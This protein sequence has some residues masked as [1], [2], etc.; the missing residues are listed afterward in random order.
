MDPHESR[1]HRRSHNNDELKDEGGQD[2][3]PHRD[4]SGGLEERQESELS[5]QSPIEGDQDDILQSKGM[6]GEEQ[7][8]QD[9]SGGLKV[10][11]KSQQLDSPDKSGEEHCLKVKGNDG[12]KRRG[13]E[14]RGRGSRKRARRVD[15]HPTESTKKKTPRLDWTQLKGLMKEERKRRTRRSS[16]QMVYLR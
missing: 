4:D 9:G 6:V 7:P 14:R 1:L 13:K 8:D 11:Q 3:Q 5:L 16:H 12:R 15:T 2:G 10:R